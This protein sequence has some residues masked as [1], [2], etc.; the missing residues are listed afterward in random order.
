MKYAIL[1]FLLGVSL[2]WVFAFIGAA[3]DARW[4]QEAAKLTG[5]ISS[6]ACLFAAVFSAIR[7][8]EK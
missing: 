5:F 3:N 2:I 6:V 1:C 7:S 4:V 8:F